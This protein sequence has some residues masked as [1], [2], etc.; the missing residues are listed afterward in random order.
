MWPEC[1]HFSLPHHT[2]VPSMERFMHHTSHRLG[3]YYHAARPIHTT[4][5]SFILWPYRSNDSCDNQ[6][7]IS[8]SSS[9][10]S[11][12]ALCSMMTHWNPQRDPLKST[13]RVG[14]KMVDIN[15]GIGRWRLSGLLANAAKQKDALLSR[16]PPSL[17]FGFLR[18]MV[19]RLS[20]SPSSSASKQSQHSFFLH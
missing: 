14:Q 8:Q 11:P 9:P 7:V 5:S 1:L 18:L 6:K 16:L 2:T 19:S 15:G 20:V 10:V 13:E 4:F 17:L 3:V 12:L